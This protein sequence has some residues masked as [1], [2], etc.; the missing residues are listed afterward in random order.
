MP[1]LTPSDLRECYENREQ[2]VPFS[3]EVKEHLAECA[4]CAAHLETMTRSLQ[5]Y[6]EGRLRPLRGRE[7]DRIWRVI[8]ANF[9]RMRMYGRKLELS[10][11]LMAGNN[12]FPEPT[13]VKDS[14]IL[15][16]WIDVAAEVRNKYSDPMPCVFARAKALCDPDKKIYEVELELPDPTIVDQLK[17]ASVTGNMK[18]DGREVQITKSSLKVTMRDRERLLTATLVTEQVSGK[19]L[20]GKEIKGPFL[21]LET[22]L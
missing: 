10:P 6:E 12:K 22:V 20:R 1:H 3:A 7:F 19:V 18:V 14:V 4:E 8:H 16:E 9:K 17:G 2:E 21:V 11:L 5:A 15:G 13:S